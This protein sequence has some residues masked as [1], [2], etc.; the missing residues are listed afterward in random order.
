MIPD[1]RLA[2][3]LDQV[4]QNQILRCLYHN[5]TT[6]SSLFSDHTCD[7]NQFPNETILELKQADEIYFLEFSHDGK[8]LATS[9]QDHVAIVYDTS[10]FQILHTL[11]EHSDTITYLSWSPDNSKIITCSLDKT[12]KIWDVTVCLSL[13]LS[14]Y[15][16]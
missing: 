14:E 12:A 9:G 5:P 4:K 16:S 1:H 11:T 6:S 10:N 3:L 15:C 2:V 7:P 13:W 8:M